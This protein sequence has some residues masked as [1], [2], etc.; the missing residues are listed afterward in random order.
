M[1]GWQGGL[2]HLQVTC[3]RDS[4]SSSSYPVRTASFLQHEDLEAERLFDYSVLAPLL[5]ATPLMTVTCHDTR[6]AGAGEVLRICTAAAGLFAGASRSTGTLLPTNLAA[7]SAVRH[8][9]GLA[10]S[11]RMC[12][13]RLLPAGSPVIFGNTDA[14]P[15]SRGRNKRLAIVPAGYSWATSPSQVRG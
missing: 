9:S 14:A 6:L 11:S 13:C 8:M 15:D 12:A 5:S 4:D 1:L 3:S 7:T 10:D 2:V